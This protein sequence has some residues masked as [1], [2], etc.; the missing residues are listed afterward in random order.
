M[1]TKKNLF[2]LV[3]AIPLPTNEIPYIKEEKTY[4][5]IETIDVIL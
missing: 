4:M 1:L 3:M 5:T 2:L